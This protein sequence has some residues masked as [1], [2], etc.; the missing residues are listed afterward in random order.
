MIAALLTSIAAMPQLMKSCKRNSTKSLSWW[1]MCLRI[2]AA[3]CWMTHGYFIEDLATI[4]SGCCVST[5]E[6]FIIGCKIRDK[7]CVNDED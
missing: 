2:I 4:I 5:W 6:I 7:Y 1:T 3:S